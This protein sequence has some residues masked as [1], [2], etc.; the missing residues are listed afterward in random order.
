M[1]FVV[2]CF[3]SLSLAAVSH[4]SAGLISGPMLSHVD[5]REASVWIQADAASTFS[6]AYSEEGSSTRQ[7]SAPVE[8]NP[9]A[10]NTARLILDQVEPGKTYRYQVLQD[11]QAVGESYTFTTPA[12]Y[13][14]ITP[15]PDFTLAV[16]GA[17]Y[18][19]QE[20]YEP[21]YQL[22]GGGYGIFQTIANAK[23]DLM[24]WL[25]N[26][27]H[28]RRSDFTT[29]SGVFKRYSAAR[30]IP[31]LTELLA[32][33][34]HYATWGD[35]DYS[36]NHAGR[37]Y[38]F[39]GFSETA[40]E[41]F[42]PQPVSVTSLQGIATRFRYSDTDFF[43]LDVR[44]YRDDAPTSARNRTILGPDQIDWLREELIRSDATFKVIVAGAPILNPAESSQNLSYADQE[45]T[46]LLEMFRSERISGLFFISGG[47][48]HGELTK[49]V[50]ANSYNLH[51]LTVG[52]L[53]ATPR[54]N[55]DELNYF[56]VPATNTVER[57]FALI[58]FAGPED[59]RRLTIR[60][61]SMEGDELWSRTLKANDLQPAESDR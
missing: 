51:D 47:K 44:S 10:A 36:P 5:M 43:V 56:R 58:D 34:P 20:G 26:T 12:N 35:A 42:W 17:H 60:L 38:S 7:T 57:H 40:F 39:R 41:A 21:P 2:L 9:S 23:P 14:D 1:R 3:A 31:E 11:G 52:P 53:T 50:H 32:T 4:L 13:Y 16:G 24:L 55:E 22:L 6:V 28:L 25:G 30:S 27:A 46:G 18:V 61:M 33:V 29:Q 8:T 59:D 15:P 45:H 19:M 48:Y 49:L 37:S 54:G